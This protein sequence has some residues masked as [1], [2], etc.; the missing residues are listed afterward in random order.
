MSYRRSG[1]RQRKDKNETYYV[2]V[3]QTYDRQGK[4]GCAAKA[5]PEKQLKNICTE[6]LELTE[7]D[8]DV[9]AERVE[10]ITV[11]G[12]DILEFHFANG[13]VLQKKWKSTARKDCWSD[14]RRREW[15]ERHKNK[16]TNPNKKRVTAFTGF[17]KCG[18][19]GADFRG[20]SSTYADGT[21]DRSWRCCEVCGNTA[22]QQK[23]QCL[24]G[25]LR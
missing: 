8:E 3:C 24:G 5:I 12:D 25:T 21:K 20:Q 11:I 15:G 1:K 7:F 4:A 16:S 9:F 2:W 13:R 18:K 17:I 22:I 23:V 19:C 10:Q 6:V 14:E